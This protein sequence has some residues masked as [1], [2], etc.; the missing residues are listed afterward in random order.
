L[1]TY[2]IAEANLQNREAQRLKITDKV[3]LRI[4]VFN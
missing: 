2:V 1:S 4:I 3:K